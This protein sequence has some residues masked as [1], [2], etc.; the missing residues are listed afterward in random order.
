MSNVDVV[1]PYSAAV[2]AC[3]AS[4]E[5]GGI[6]SDPAKGHVRVLK[7]MADHM[8][9]EAAAGRI[10][11]V[12]ID[13]VLNAVGTVTNQE[14]AAKGQK[15]AVADGNLAK[16]LRHLDLT[17]GA[18][19]KDGKY[20]VRDVDQR[21]EAAAKTHPELYGRSHQTVEVKVKLNQ[22]GLLVA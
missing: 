12:Y 9:A 22:A 2:R 5:A 1:K 15:A 10:P 17:P 18:G 20:T 8:D 3:A 21:L 6:G 4:M 13:G 7:H 19:P 16:Y 11:R 14:L